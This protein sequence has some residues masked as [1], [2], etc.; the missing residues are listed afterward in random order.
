MKF[1]Y[2]PVIKIPKT[3]MEKILDL[4][5]GTFF[6]LSLVFILYSWVDI[7]DR[8]PG[9]FNALGEVDRWGSKYEIII[10]PIMG[11]FLFFLLSLFEKAPHMHNYPKR[12]NENNVEQFYINSR[13]T[14]NIVKNICLIIFATLIVQIVRVS[15]GDIQSLGIWFLPIFIGLLFLVIIISLVQRSKIK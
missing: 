10:L 2:R 11:M 5:G 4:I 1:P 6:L 3:R 14:L 13:Q 15:K 7:P 9:H 8:I 12:L